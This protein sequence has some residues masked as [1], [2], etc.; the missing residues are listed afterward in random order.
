MKLGASTFKNLGLGIVRRCTA[1]YPAAVHQDNTQTDLRDFRAVF[2][3]HWNVC[4]KVW[5]LLDDH[6]CY[7]KQRKPEHLLWAMLFLKSYGSEQVNSLIVGTTAKTY[8]KWVWRVVE[9]VSALNVMV[10][11]DRDSVIFCF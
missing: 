3:V 6:G 10:V 11:R 9:E 1:E 2:G 8:R 4:E 7:Q 5:N